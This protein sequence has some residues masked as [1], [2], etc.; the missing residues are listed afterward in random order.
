MPNSYAL[1][2]RALLGFPISFLLSCSVALVLF[3]GLTAQAQGTP[4]PAPPSVAGQPSGAPPADTAAAPSAST[5]ETRPSPR[6]T[7]PP[8]PPP[9]PPVSTYDAENPPTVDYGPWE[10][11]PWG[12]ASLIFGIPIWLSG[13]G[14]AV[15]PGFSIGGRFGWRLEDIIPEINTGYMINWFDDEFRDRGTLSNWWLGF[16]M[17]WQPQTYSRFSPYAGGG[18]QLNFWHVSGDEVYA[19]DFYYCNSYNNY[20]FAPGF[21]ATAGIDIELHPAIALELGGLFGLTFP[22]TLFES[23]QT[24]ISPQFGITGHFY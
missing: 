6:P 3:V 1:R 18:V 10:P 17:R 8:P 7:A 5:P 12:Q 23:T 4:T 13:V 16:G 19:C 14:D 15:S 22:G 20:R 2:H 21:T 24:W 9:L 11:E